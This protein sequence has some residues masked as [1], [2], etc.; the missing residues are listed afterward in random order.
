MEVCEH[1]K[2][3]LGFFT[4]IQRKKVCNQCM[5]NLIKPDGDN[6]LKKYMN[7]E[8]L[9]FKRLNEDKKSIIKKNVINYEKHL[10]EVP[11]LNKEWK[12]E[13]KDK[14]N[15]LK[16]VLSDIKKLKRVKILEPTVKE[17]ESYLITLPAWI[18]Q[19]IST[20][21]FVTGNFGSKQNFDYKLNVVKSLKGIKKIRVNGKVNGE[22]KFNG[23]ITVYGY[24]INI[25][26]KESTP[27]FFHK[28]EL[29]ITGN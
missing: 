9:D 2:K 18:G 17:W 1:C 3:K 7:E 5:R 29:K 14:I 21:S 24:K 22:N 8:G 11:E 15:E 6:F 27:T 20:I 16:R 26:K 28:N 23:E 10:G 13:N 4:R 12:K 25:G 19:S